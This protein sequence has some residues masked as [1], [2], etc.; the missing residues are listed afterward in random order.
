LSSADFSRAVADIVNG[1]RAIHIW[2]TL[3]WQEIRQRYRR[4]V[5]G[6]FWLTV[7]VGVLVGGMGPLYGRMFGQDLSGYFPHLAIS[8]V[9]WLLI[10]NLLNESCLAF[11]A[12]EGLIKQ[13][14]MPLTV[15]VLRVVWRNLL[16]FFHHAVILLLVLLFYTPP[17]RWGL[18]LAPLGVLAIAVNAIWFGLF[19]GMLCA[20]FRD[21][22]LIMG[23]VVQVMFFLTPVLWKPEFLGRHAWAADWNPINHLLEVVRAPLV[24]GR[25]PQLSWI[26][27][28]GM[29]VVG[30]ALVLPLFAR[31]RSRIAY[32]V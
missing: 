1:I 24:D 5:L 13:A 8:F 11:I 30:F 28:I 12:A 25:V 32:W 17:L 26:V 22:P 19:L 3:G 20:R 9:T 16:I 4:S 14:R 10:A 2:P 23:S 31:Y 15:H 29:T 27:V 7:S 21:L 18:L 6:P